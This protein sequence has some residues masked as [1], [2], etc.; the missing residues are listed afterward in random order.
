MIKLIKILDIIK[1]LKRF[2]HNI[3]FKL[4]KCKN[5]I[6]NFP[7]FKR[8]KSQH[9][10]MITPPNQCKCHHQTIF[11]RYPSFIKQ[12][13]QS[14]NITE[15]TIKKKEYFVSSVQ[16]FVKD[17][18]SKKGYK[19]IKDALNNN[20]VIRLY[21]DVDCNIYW[22]Y[23][24][25]RKY[26]PAKIS[27]HQRLNGFINGYVLSRKDLLYNNYKI[28]KKKFPN[29]FT[30]MPETYIFKSLKEYNVKFKDY[31]ISKDNLWLVKPRY[32]Y[33]GKGIYFL[34]NINEVKK[35][36]IITKYISNPL[37][38]NNRK[39]DIRLY[40]L[41]TGHNPLKIYIFDEGLVRLSSEEYNLDIND[42]DNRFKHLT[43][44]SINKKNR[45]NK[46]LTMS[47]A[48]AKKYIEE[49]YKIKFSNIWEGIKDI[50]IK[51]IISMNN[52]EI[53]KEKKY[54]LN[55]NNLFELYGMDIMV[56]S[57]FKTWLIEM[58]CNPSLSYF[59]AEEHNKIIKYKLVHDL[60]NIIGLVPY[61]HITGKALEKECY[62]DNSIEEAVDQ[63]ICEFLRPLGG[64]EQIFPTKENIKY[65]M[66]FFKTITP[67]NQA[68]WDK[69]DK[70][71]F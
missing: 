62:Y 37:L 69:I 35:G 25:I 47:I 46:K 23:S 22:R 27:K 50:A 38:I 1:V 43:N 14:Y 16:H 48:E 59:Q 60:F 6:E 41:V 61:S 29:D 18:K 33:G 45:K 30:Y 68:L 49:F 58:N 10:Y 70:E 56:D 31:H 53:E 71:K 4:I 24:Y 52:I 40:L 28:M 51:T 15:V 13:F 63:S 9:L 66:K 54:T 17:I 44:T 21:N 8:I 67:N 39:F 32:L 65:Y 36:N 26:L 3:N 55:S 2:K 64:F 5:L 12:N 7:E 11:F 19:C 20:N 34:K 42:L 57:N